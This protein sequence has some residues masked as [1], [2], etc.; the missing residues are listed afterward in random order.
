VTRIFIRFLAITTGLFLAS[1]LFA[2]IEVRGLVPAL[3]A[4]LFIGILNFTIKPVL[5]FLTFPVN[6]LTLGLFGLVL[7][8][9][10]LWFV[11]SVVGG[12]IIAGFFP[13]LGC[14][15]IISLFNA[16]ANTFV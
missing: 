10:I 5:I 12:V 13:A 1:Y 6:F 7:N 3:V 11:A 15:V 9:L 14:A 8:A 4:V 16:F 2:G